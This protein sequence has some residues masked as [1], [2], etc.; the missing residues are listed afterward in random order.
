MRTLSLSPFYII[1]LTSFGLGLSSTA[2]ADPLHNGNTLG[3]GGAAIAAIADDASVALNPAGLG[4]SERYDF[5]GAAQNVVGGYALGGK[6]VDSRTGK[7]GFGLSYRY[8]QTNDLTANGGL[9]GWVTS[10]DEPSNIVEAHQVVAAIGVPFFDRKLAIGVNGS[11]AWIDSNNRGLSNTFDMGLGV[12]ARPLEWLSFG[13]VG[14]DLL[15]LEGLE[16]KNAS[17]A[18]GIQIGHQIGQIVTDVRW[19][20]GATDVSALSLHT[21]AELFLNSARLRAGYLQLG[22]TGVSAFTWGIGNENPAGGIEYAMLVPTN[23]A[24]WRDLQHTLSIRIRTPKKS[25]L[26]M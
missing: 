26:R 16:E 11:G 2:A 5:S 24:G 21:G 18:G 9:P 8:D 15:N 23:D 10:G 25:R 6:V 22:P 14:A 13:L 4:M 1:L 17:V 19:T 7:F 3:T 20:S 12:T